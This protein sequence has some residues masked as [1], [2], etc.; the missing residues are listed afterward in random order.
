MGFFL[1][2][3]FQRCKHRARGGAAVVAVVLGSLAWGQAGAQS[4]TIRGFAA[5]ASDGQPLQGV[6]VT[7]RGEPGGF[8]GA[9]SDAD[10]FFALARVPAGTYALSASFIGYVTHR[11]TLRLAPGEARTLRIGLTP[12]EAELREV[13]V[14]SDVAIGGGAGSSAGLQRVNPSDIEMVPAPDVTG[15]LVS[16]LGIMP[17]VVASGDRGGQ[18]FIRGGEPAQ[19]LVLVDGI[20][21]YQPFHLVGFYSAFP[22]DI[23]RSTDVYAGGFGGRYGGRL[24]SVIDISARH[25]NKRRV[26]ASVSAAPF[27]SGVRVEGPL[28]TDRVSLLASY[29]HSVIDELAS[30]VVDQPLPF[31]FSDGFGKVHG[32]FGESQIS[33]SA[34]RTTDRG[35]LRTSSLASRGLASDEVRW[36]NE[37][38]GGR[39]LFLPGRVPMLAELLLS[40]SF[41]ENSFG[42]VDEPTRASSARQYNLAANV[43][44]FTSLVDFAWGL[45]LRTS[46]LD[47]RLAGQF[48]N[49]ILRREYVTE[50]GAYLEPE[51]RVGTRLRIQPGLRAQTFPSKNRT[52]LEPRLRAS[53]LSG[54]H[55]LSGA[56]GVYHQEIVGLAD[57]RDAGDVFTAWTSSPF[58]RV[59][60]ATHVI[61][62]YNLRLA[63]GLALSVEAFRKWLSDLFVA[64]WT[65]FPR[66][67]TRLQPADGDVTGLDLRLEFARGRFYALASYGVATVRYTARGHATVN[68]YGERGRRFNPPHDR[69]HQVNV[70]AGLLI[71]GIDLSA[72]WQYGSGLPFTQALGFD[73]FVYI[74]GPADVTNEA[75]SVRVLYGP[76]Y[77][78]RLPA[79]HRLDISV[80]R[81][82]EPS[83][84]LHVTIQA[85]AINSY[86]RLNLFYL[87]LYTLNRVDQLPLIPS[88]GLRMDIL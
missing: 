28:W 14:E 80:E 44:Q 48:Q 40:G 55:R 33:V 54:P 67:T 88:L 5:D 18:L 13:V 6:N 50:A 84:H 16:Y 22:A 24:S 85:S 81:R 86:D 11:D 32:S 79:Y 21:V 20:L 52:F 69:R 37:A 46:V 65:A 61:L 60:A 76:P 82:F 53:W 57:R 43:T 26:E 59:P 70:L 39:Y 19:N 25:G 30:R 74:D 72:R 66:F 58:G 29:R 75:G 83:R 1:L 62:G 42:P 36:K 45:F 17:G 41:V 4:V 35:R 63:G 51:L 12:D 15:D 8:F 31:W 10:G 47:S 71:F 56:W 64:E 73:T 87:D 7:L 9:A 49:V 27:V 77:E 23:I 3:S 78:G 68:W 34:L 38:I 2:T